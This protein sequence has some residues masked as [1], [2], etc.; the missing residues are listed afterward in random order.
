VG[1]WFADI[2]RERIAPTADVRAKAAELVR[3]LDSDEA[4]A[5]AIYDFVSKEIRYIGLEF[6]IGR[7]Q[8]NPASSVLANGYGDCKD[9]HTLLASMLQV[10]GINASPVLIHTTRKLDPDVPSLSQ[11]DHLFTSVTLGKRRVFLDSTTEV[12]PFGMLVTVL[13]DKQ[14]LLVDPNGTQ[15]VTTPA[16]LPF[17]QFQRL[18][19]TGKVDDK[20]KVNAEIVQTFRGDLELALRLAFRHSGGSKFKEVAQG[21]AALTGFGGEVSN[22]IVSDLEN[23]RV[24]LQVKY[25]YTRDDYLSWE[26]DSGTAKVL[27]PAIGLVAA[28][29]RA[30]ANAEPITLGSPIEIEYEGKLEYPGEV[31]IS[32]PRNVDM[33]RGYADYHSTY[34]L[35]DNTLT[36][37]RRLRVKARKVPAEK[38]SD[39]AEFAKAV[40]NDGWQNATASR[41]PALASSPGSRPPEPLKPSE[42]TAAQTAYEEGGR[43]IM[44][45]DLF[46]ARSKFQEAARLDPKH[47]DAWTSLARLYLMR[48]DYQESERLLRKQLEV[49]PRHPDANMMLAGVLF[50]RGDKEGATKALQAQIDVN[51]E[52]SRAYSYLGSVYLMDRKYKEA[53]PLLEKAAGMAPDDSN[54]KLGLGTAYLGAGEPGKA[55]ATYEKILAGT[56][57]PVMMND[58]AYSLAEYGVQVK[59][60]LELSKQAASRL[61][62]LLSNTRLAD[63]SIDDIRNTNAL[64]ATWDTVG[65]V[66]YKNGDLENAKNYLVATWATLQNHE[67]ADHLSAVYDSMGEK[68]QAAE[69]RSYAQAVPEPRRVTLREGGDTIGLPDLST[70]RPMTPNSVTQRLQDL[71]TVRLSRR[72][73]ATEHAEFFVLLSPAG[74]EDASFINGSDVLKSWTETLKNTK[75]PAAFP[76]G[77]AGKLVRR[78]ILSCS[79][80]NG[81]CIFVFYEPRQVRLRE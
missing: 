22:V 45:G 17:E 35:E 69:Y 61:E 31:I 42:N 81:E 23:T 53:I 7:Y 12:A 50:V 27:I 72:L 1:R 40:F 54:V 21:I 63:L 32:E 76:E 29:T 43:A 28:D 19:G 24:P 18:E 10:V 26:G 8:A 41:R 57:S 65:W 37:T 25:H 13:R 11:F 36:V 47:P 6:G 38:R 33:S 71:R 75:V 4:K 46:T 60:A 66:Y 49:N 78:G 30:D 9:K 68:G 20:G 67:V 16:E 34:K 51:P 80:H 48:N 3:G 14:A 55:T 62:A 77:S 15:I 59:H 52:D 56:P 64:L 39:Y 2:Q 5:E 74:I 44:R 58:I 70:A 73:N 79:S